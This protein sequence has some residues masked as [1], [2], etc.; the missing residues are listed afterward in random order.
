MTCARDVTNCVQDHE[1][2]RHLSA[3]TV[4][5]QSDLTDSLKICSIMRSIQVVCTVPKPIADVGDGYCNSVYILTA[6]NQ[7]T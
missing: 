5:M 1:Y 2:E 7:Y 3:R 4:L 6:V